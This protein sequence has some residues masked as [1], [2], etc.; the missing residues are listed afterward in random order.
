MSCAAN[1]QC[2][3]SAQGVLLCG[4]GGSVSAVTGVYSDMQIQTFAPVAD[5]LVQQYEQASKIGSCAVNAYAKPL[6]TAS[7]GAASNGGGKLTEPFWSKK[8]P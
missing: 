7:N 6:A 1:Q 2:M 3:Y 5:S 4:N 8:M